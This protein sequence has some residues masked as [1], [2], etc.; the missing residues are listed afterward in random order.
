MVRLVLFDIDGTLIRTGGAG[1]R[2]FART[3]EI[4][5]QRPN[6]THSLNF[7]GRTDTSLVGEFL[8]LHGFQDDPVHRERFVET[9]LFLLDAHMEASPGEACPGVP[10]FVAQLEKLPEPP[11]LGLLTGNVRLGAEIKLRAHG[12]W[13]WFQ[14]GAFGDDHEDR[15]VLAR[16]AVDRGQKLLARPL[17]GEEVL[18][19]GD[20]HR[21]IECAAAVGA[22]CLAV[23]TGGSTVAD[24]AGFHPTWVVETLSGID[25]RGICG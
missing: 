3:S 16:I 21:D 1:V 10:E 14:M 19:I 25:V 17:A 4:A 2:A 11:L 6:G 13:E 9:Y 24:L 5:F 12:M 15:N 23:A 7:A 8:R 18:V 20:T 22:R